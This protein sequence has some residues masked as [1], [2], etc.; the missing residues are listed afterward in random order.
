MKKIRRAKVIYV[1]ETH[2]KVNGKTYYLWVFTTNKITVF[3]IRKSRGEDVIHEVLGKKFQYTLVC[4]GWKVYA[5]YTNN[6][7]RCWAHLLRE[8]K[9]LAKEHK[10]AITLYDHL[11][12]IFIQVRAITTRTP[13]ELRKK[14]YTSLITQLQQWVDYTENFKELRKFGTKIKNGIKFWCTRV[15][16]PTVEPTN[17][18]AEQKLR[19]PI[20]QRKIFGTLRNEK[21]TRIMEIILSVITTWK[22]N[23][24][25]VKEKIASFI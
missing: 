17:N 7:Q 5:S 14:I 10:S 3:V 19:E 25:P 1:D 24:I 15:L 22:N 6:L 13:E 8:S 11:N 18:F 12:R 16:K 21:G 4:D 23:G 9:F 20:V 2:I